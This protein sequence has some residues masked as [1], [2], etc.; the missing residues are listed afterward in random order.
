MKRATWICGILIVCALAVSRCSTVQKILPTTAWRQARVRN[1][2]YSLLYQLLSQESDAAK[3]LI[4][5]HADPPIA[6]IIKEIASTCDQA[7]KE[8]EQFHEKYRDLSLEMTHLPQIEQQTRAAIESTVTKQLLFSSGKKF[9]VRFL[10]T[11]AEAMNYAAH[12]AQVL[13]DQEDNPVR[14]EFLATLSER[15]TTLRDRVMEL[16]KY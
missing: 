16:L 8:L 12:L 15:C 4:I 6:D 7:R 2:G 9:E 11:Q 14:K 10:F 13:H 5:K 1:E 3:I